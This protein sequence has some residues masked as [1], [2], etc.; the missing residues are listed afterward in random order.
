[1]CKYFVIIMTFLA[2]LFCIINT[3]IGDPIEVEITPEQEAPKYIRSVHTQKRVKIVGVQAPENAQLIKAGVLGDI[4]EIQTVPKHAVCNVLIVAP[5]VEDQDKGK[6]VPKVGNDELNKLWCFEGNSCPVKLSGVNHPLPE[7]Y[8]NVLLVGNACKLAVDE[9]DYYL[10]SDWKQ[11]MALPDNIKKAIIKVRVLVD[12]EGKDVEKDF[13]WGDP[14]IM[15]A[16]ELLF[17]TFPHSFAGR[18][19]LNI[20][21]PALLEYRKANK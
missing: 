17:M 13:F 1:M 7:Y 16:K 3:S 11:L 12:E 5:E 15:N 9:P 10:A 18:N 6:K 4:I 19:D 14:A 8:W 21:D 2:F 20:V